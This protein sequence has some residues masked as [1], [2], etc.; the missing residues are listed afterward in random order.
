[1]TD[2][3]PLIH[4]YATCTVENTSLNKQHRYLR[5]CLWYRKETLN[6]WPSVQKASDSRSANLV[7]IVRTSNLCAY[8]EC[9]FLPWF[10]SSIKL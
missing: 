1:M 5:M 3:R 9:K 2:N 7:P 8:G 4:H 10:E 6:L